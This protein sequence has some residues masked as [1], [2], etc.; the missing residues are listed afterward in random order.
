M[1]LLR[2]TATDRRL[3]LHG[4]SDRVAE[5]VKAQGR[6]PGPAIIMLHG[7]KYAPGHPTHC[8]H[9]KIFSETG[10]GW[11]PAL[12]FNRGSADEGL[13]IAFGW[14]ARGMLWEAHRRAAD[15][16]HALAALIEMLRTAAP[17]RPIHLIAHSLGSEIALSALPHV[18][19]GAIDRVVLLTGASFSSRAQDSL[20]SPAGA[21]AEVFN[22]TSRE[23]D[24]FDLAFERMVS[25]P[26]QGD[27]AVGQGLDLP[28]T[29]NLQLDC[30]DTLSVLDGLGLPIAA[31]Q[32]PICHWS[33]YRR[34]GV[35]ALYTRLLR[36]P[37]S[38]PQADLARLLPANAAPRWSRLMAP[39][40]P[41]AHLRALSG[42]L[43]ST[44]QI[45][46]AKTIRLTAR[47]TPEK[48]KEPA[49]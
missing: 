49:F 31:S 9:M 30:P 15:L 37:E 18:R 23:N 12:G 38:L 42:K 6:G 4:G 40:L 14:Y 46:R 24:L 35:M 21:A 28:N 2:I 25:A 20:R 36:D 32:R 5:A 17:E 16:G 7:Y 8:P 26:R 19:A 45:L 34:P 33:S 3:E 48:A 11:P 44:A 1:P 10:K 27:R 39:D 29:T 47:T 43:L 22:I 41:K 13:G